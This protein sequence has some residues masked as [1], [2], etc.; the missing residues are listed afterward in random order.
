MTLRKRKKGT[1]TRTNS[2]SKTQAKE[3]PREARV[4][5]AK[6]DGARIRD[7]Y[8]ASTGKTTAVRR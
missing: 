5:T 3:K 2:R 1:T 7:L 6:V 4:A 8:D